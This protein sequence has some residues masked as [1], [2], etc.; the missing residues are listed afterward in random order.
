MDQKDNSGALFSNKNKKQ[1][2]HPDYTGK[3]VVNGEAMDL[4]AWVKTSKAGDKYL[5]L[6]FK[7]PYN[8]DTHAQTNVL[9][10]GNSDLPF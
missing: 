6:A 9:H 4:S 10:I 8:A 1:E 3:C 2:T 7:K 5:S